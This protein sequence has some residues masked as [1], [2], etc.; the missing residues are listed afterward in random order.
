MEE[1]DA[2]KDGSNDANK[3]EKKSSTEEHTDF[4]VHLQGNGFAEQN[5]DGYD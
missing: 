2:V 4:I 3:E 5:D 1:N